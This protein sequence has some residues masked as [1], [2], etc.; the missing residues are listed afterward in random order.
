MPEAHKRFWNIDLILCEAT[1]CNKG[2]P[3]VRKQ[4]LKGKRQ[5][6][7]MP[8]YVTN[9]QKS[10]ILKQLQQDL[11]LFTRFG[12]MDYSMIVGI[13]RPPPGYSQQVLEQSL[14]QLHS[15]PYASYYQGDTTVL[16]IG[17]IDFLQVCERHAKILFFKVLEFL[18]CSSQYFWSSNFWH[19]R[20]A[21]VVRI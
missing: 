21:S 20:E 16:F 2:V 19:G 3:F 12:L 11:A 9:E 10:Y 4:Y 14:S 7:E 18:S 8:I 1:G 6:Y 17:I 13:Y 15:I 5:A